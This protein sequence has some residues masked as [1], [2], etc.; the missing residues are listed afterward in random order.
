MP[1]ANCLFYSKVNGGYAQYNLKK[2]FLGIEGMTSTVLEDRDRFLGHVRNLAASEEPMSCYESADDAEYT[3]NRSAHYCTSISFCLNGARSAS[4]IKQEGPCDFSHLST[5]SRHSGSSE[6]RTSLLPDTA[7]THNG[8]KQCLSSYFLDATHSTFPG[9][10]TASSHSTSTQPQPGGRRG[11]STD[12]A[13]IWGILRSAHTFLPSCMNNI[14]VS[15]PRT[16][17]NSGGVPNCSPPKA[18]QPEGLCGLPSSA[19]CLLSSAGGYEL[20]SPEQVNVPCSE[21]SANLFLNT[22]PNDCSKLNFLKQEPEDSYP[23]GLHSP[24][25]LTLSMSPKTISPDEQDELGNERRQLCRWIDCSAFYDQQEELVRHIEK[26][27][28]DQRTGE[29]FTCFW[30]GCTRRFKPFNARYKLLI[31]MRVHSGEKPNKCMFEGCNKAFSRLENLKIHLRSHTGERP[32]VCQHPG[33][34]KAF[35][36]SSDR[37]KHQRTHQDTKPYACQIPG[38]CKRYTDPS[39]L[40]KHVKAHTVKEQQLR[41]KAHHTLDGKWAKAITNDIINGTRPCDMLT[42]LYNLCSNNQNLASP[43]LLSPVSSRCSALDSPSSCLLSVA[44]SA[45]ERMSPHVLNHL[46]SPMKSTVSSSLLHRGSSP[47]SHHKSHHGQQTL[48]GKNYRTFHSPQMQEFQGTFVQYPDCYRE[49]PDPDRYHGPCTQN[50]GY[51]FN[52]TNADGNCLPENG[53]SN[54]SQERD[55]FPNAAFDHCIPQIPSIYTDT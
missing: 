54:C 35:S 19:Q 18:S 43:G 6:L 27:H 28:I 8:L 49:T 48:V 5:G 29:D 50:T 39:S 53:R 20:K 9:S 23:Q 47:G 32:Y 55:F 15:P 13:E 52:N 4:R 25:H 24:L 11:C 16:Q 44:E 33:C 3:N 40:R 45:L 41:N 51:G 42:G 30:A 37:A 22:I 2:S 21:G 26:T 34:Q 38:C 14:C 17:F 10:L 7:L 36:N 1:G 12:S 46:P 31:H